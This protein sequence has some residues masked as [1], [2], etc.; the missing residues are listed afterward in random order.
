MLAIPPNHALLVGF[1]LDGATLQSISY[2]T[3]GGIPHSKD[4]RVL[5]RSV[6]PFDASKIG[7]AQIRAR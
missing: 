5:K 6:A 7:V 2:E 3:L 1:D 4:I